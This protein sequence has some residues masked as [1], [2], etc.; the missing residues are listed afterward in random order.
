MAINIIDQ[1]HTRVV[2]KETCL[3]KITTEITH[4]SFK[5]DVCKFLTLLKHTNSIICLQ[6]FKK[7]AKLRCLSE[8]KNY[9]AVSYSPFKMC[10]PSRNVGLCFGLWNP[11]TA[12]LPNCASAPWVASWWKTQCISCHS[13]S[14][15]LV[16]VGV[17]NLAT[18]MCIKS[19]EEVPGEKNILFSN[20]FNLDCNT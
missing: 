8:K 11:P 4:F 3:K 16:P 15:A 17:V 1:W 10:I 6:I 9:A 13:S 7:N 20:I 19:E 5:G 2:W 12:S 14:C 18:C